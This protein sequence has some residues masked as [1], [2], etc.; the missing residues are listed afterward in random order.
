[1]PKCLQRQT[2]VMY[3]RVNS[4]HSHHTCEPKSNSNHLKLASCR[5]MAMSAESEWS[6]ELRSCLCFEQVWNFGLT[7]QQFWYKFLTKIITFFTNMLQNVIFLSSATVWKAKIKGHSHQKW[8]NNLFQKWLE[9]GH[10]LLS[11]VLM[12]NTYSAMPPAWIAW[13]KNVFRLLKSCCFLFEVIILPA[14]CLDAF[15]K[16]KPVS[17]LTCWEW[18]K[19]WCLWL[20][21]GEWAASVAVGEKFWRGAGTFRIIPQKA[22]QS[23]PSKHLCMFWCGSSYKFRG[24]VFRTLWHEQRR[25]KL[26]QRLYIPVSVD[27]WQV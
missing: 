15:E 9:S 17:I 11:L 3:T 23:L 16:E 18:R 19:W 25:T 20:T 14:L 13:Q 26:A 5:V 1:M 2:R 6:R 21:G 24:T 10:S 8:L 12:N 27:L 4:S 7:R 22:I